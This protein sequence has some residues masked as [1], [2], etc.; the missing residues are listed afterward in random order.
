MKKYML[1]S[2]TFLVISILGFAQDVANDKK[3]Y[4]SEDAPDAG[5]VQELR[6]KIH[7]AYASYSSPVKKEK[8]T[9]AR[10]LGDFIPGYPVNWISDYLSVE[11]LATCNG[12]VMKAL[13]TND[14]LSAEQKNILI[15][16]D[17]ATDIVINA[18]YKYKNSVTGHPDF[19]SMHYTT[20]LVPEI[21]AEF[22]GG[23]KKLINYF[24]ENVINKISETTPKEFQKG[25]VLFTVNEKG[26][27]VNAKIFMSSGD[28]K[29][30]NLLI[31]AINKMPTW[32][33]AEN[34]KGKKVKQEFEFSINGIDEGC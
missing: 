31:D 17:L 9:E 22:I 4:R 32:R 1:T 25:K 5:I 14:V 28:P 27:I 18:N 30:D 34:S 33:P 19:R 21:E 29:T 2:A 8:L 15:T 10:L 23:N 3:W 11:I 20:T 16:A 6:F 24:K 26:A 7:P 12:K 13:S